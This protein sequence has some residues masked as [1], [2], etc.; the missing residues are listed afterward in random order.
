[1]AKKTIIEHEKQTFLF[2]GKFT[3]PIEPNLDLSKVKLSD[4]DFT[5]SHLVANYLINKDRKTAVALYEELK[6]Q[7]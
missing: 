4:V 7:L 5:N 3:Q 1:M 6:Y 2:D